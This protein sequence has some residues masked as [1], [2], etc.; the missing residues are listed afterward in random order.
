MQS[1][2]TAKFVFRTSDENRTRLEHHAKRLG[3]T[4]NSLVREATSAYL[5]LLDIKEAE[6][7]KNRLAG[8]GRGLA[9]VPDH[10]TPQGLGPTRAEAKNTAP[11]PS[12]PPPSPFAA[13]ASPPYVIPDKV[14]KAFRGWAEYLEEADGLVESERRARKIVDDIKERVEEKDVQPCYEA[15]VDFCTERKDSKPQPMI[16]IGDVTLVGDV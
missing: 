14:K 15:F 4:M 6:S 2:N 10:V 11:P 16:A 9:H 3:A 12:Q 7:K 13:L 8:R 5:D 1:Q